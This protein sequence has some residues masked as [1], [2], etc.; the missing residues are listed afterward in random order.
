M[1]SFKINV[2]SKTIRKL[3]GWVRDGCNRRGL[4][5]LTVTRHASCQNIVQTTDLSHANS[6]MIDY[7]LSEM[8]IIL[9]AQIR[10]KIKLK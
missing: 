2:A 3:I 7:Q 1:F 5:V 4:S 9:N 10:N 8:Q 6:D